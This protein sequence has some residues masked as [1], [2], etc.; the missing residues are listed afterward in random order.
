MIQISE[1]RV[2]ADASPATA[3]ETA[4]DLVLVGRPV[5]LV[6]Q[7]HLILTPSRIVLDLLHFPFLVKCLLASKPEPFQPFMFFKY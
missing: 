6:S 4:L 3:R 5:P 2:V 1:M 7:V